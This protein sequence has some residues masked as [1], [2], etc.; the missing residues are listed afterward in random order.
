MGGMEG[1]PTRLRRLTRA[2]VYAVVVAVPIALLALLIRTK[3]GPLADLDQAVS[4]RATDFTRE[5]DGFHTAAHTWEMISQPWVMYAVLGVPLCLLAWFHWRL[6]TRAWWALA[7]MATGWILAA[8]LKMLVQ[9]ARP[10]IDDPFAVHHGYSFPSGHATNNAIVVTVLLLLLRPVLGVTM[11]RLLLALGAA[12]V[13]ITCADRLFM[14]AHFLS[15]VTAGVL[16][17]VGLCIASYAGYVG[18][19]PPDP[20]DTTSKESADDDA[21]QV[22]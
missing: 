4:E 18:W 8:A 16:L 2:V 14:G 7:T 21:H 22:A 13:L 9:R 19:S 3:F 6:R 12:W 15:D 20:T 11:R 17:G 1:H 10:A 5:H